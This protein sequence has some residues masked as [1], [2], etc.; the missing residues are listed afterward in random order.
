MAGEPIP[1]DVLSSWEHDKI[2]DVLSRVRLRLTDSGVMPRT[3][4]THWRSV[5]S[6]EVSVRPH[7][8]SFTYFS[9]CRLSRAEP[10]CQPS[11]VWLQGEHDIATKDVL[12]AT[13]AQAIALNERAVVID[14]S[15]IDFISAATVGAIVDAERL[16]AGRGRSLLVRA[17]PPFVR[18]IFAVLGLSDLFGPEPPADAPQAVKPPV[19]LGSWVEVET[20]GGRRSEDTSAT[21]EPGQD[22]RAS[23][24]SA[25]EE[26]PLFVK[27][28]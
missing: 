23:A 7:T 27:I 21:A 25:P 16:L 12:V 24:G 13:L 15:G 8:S 3:P 5:A 2:L 22:E 20:T 19:A 28:P 1:C 18:R 6:S 14:L 9:S 11:V 17:P 4:A 10:A 26:L